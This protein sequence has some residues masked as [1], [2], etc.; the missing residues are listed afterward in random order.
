MRY[1]TFVQPLND[2]GDPEY[3][4]MSEEEIRNDYY[5]YWYKKMSAK[6]GHKYVDDNYTFEDCLI[7]WIIVNW[8]WESN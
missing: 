1:F 2:A 3:V 8:A 7:E 4:T 5:P 6:Y